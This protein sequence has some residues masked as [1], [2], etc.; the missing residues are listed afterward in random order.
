MF[1]HMQ[2]VHRE[3]ITKVPNAKKGRESFDDHVFAMEGVPAD[4]IQDRL[5]LKGKERRAAL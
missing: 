5:Q 3:N 1:M 4:L 2:Q